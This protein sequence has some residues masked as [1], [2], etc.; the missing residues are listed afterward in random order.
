MSDTTTTVTDAAE[1]VIVP[2]DV[3]ERHRRER[4]QQRRHVAGTILDGDAEEQEV[5]S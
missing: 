5:A 2:A 1:R 3:F 4:E